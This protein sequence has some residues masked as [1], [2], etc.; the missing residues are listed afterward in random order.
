MKTFTVALL[1]LSCALLKAQDRSREIWD[2]GFLQKRPGPAN[3]AGHAQSNQTITYKP[4]SADSK[5][6]GPMRE[7]GLGLTIW[8][9]RPVTTR[10]NRDTRLLV[11]DTGG[12][13]VEMIPE[14]IDVSKPLHSGDRIRIAIEVPRRG[15]LYVIDRERYRAGTLGDP[16]L[17]FPALNINHGGNQVEPGQLV[18]IPPQNSTVR[19]LKLTT[20][21]EQHIGEDLM[22]IV[23]PEP[24]KEITPAEGEQSLPSDLVNRW[25]HDWTAESL[26]FNLED[27]H[28]DTWTPIEKKAGNSE[29]SYRLTQSDPMPATILGIAHRGAGP[30]V[31]HV[32]IEIE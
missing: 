12:A 27:A 26:K 11:Q 5:H 17:I 16:A 22:L 2:T 18:E 29:T 9:L 3:K 20:H 14:R 6:M 13:A 15:Y 19:A 10:D 32:S 1:L 4:Q 21:G 24:L 8:R 25:D 23:S 31:I 30:F 28:I 7:A